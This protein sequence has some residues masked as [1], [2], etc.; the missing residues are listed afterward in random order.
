MAGGLAYSAPPPLSSVAGVARAPRGPPGGGSQPF[1]GAASRLAESVWV[2]WPRSL[3]LQLHRNGAKLRRLR[4]ASSGMTCPG[5][6]ATAQDARRLPFRTPLALR[7]R[8]APRRRAGP[9]ELRLS[10]H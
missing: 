2:G 3:L 7:G 6:Y 10:T 4:H 9:Q 5:A 8:T 1:G